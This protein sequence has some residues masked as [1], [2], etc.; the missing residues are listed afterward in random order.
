MIPTLA[1][2]VVV[3]RAVTEGIKQVLP[4]VFNREEFAKGL[5]FV[6]SAIAVYY[7]KLDVL[8]AVGMKT[9]VWQVSFLFNSLVLAVA[10]M[11]GHDFLDALAGKR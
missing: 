2:L 5:V 9:P 11:G 10:T 7:Y 3:I 1:I 6:L 8:S 4:G